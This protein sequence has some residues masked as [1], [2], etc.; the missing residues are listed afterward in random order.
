MSTI[1]GPAL[2]HI[3]GEKPQGLIVILHGYGASGDNLISLGYEWQGM[4]PT[5]DFVAPNGIYPWEGGMF[6]GYQWFSLVDWDTKRIEGEMDLIRP[7]LI[8]YLNEELSKRGLTFNDLVL[9][10][11]SQGA[12]LALDLGLHG[13]EK[14]AGVIAYSGGYVSSKDIRDATVP[15]LLIHGAEDEVLA[16][17]NSL[18]AH[19]TLQNA[20]VVSQLHILDNLEHSIDHRGLRLGAEF[21]KKEFNQ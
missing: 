2:T 17:E 16:S 19:T 3:Q 20:G 5:L 13:K 12:V 11:F 18:V 7:K 4:L 10:G 1:F 15:I 6:G 8:E 21:L 9:V 14:P